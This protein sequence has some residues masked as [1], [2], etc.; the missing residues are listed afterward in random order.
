MLSEQNKISIH[1]LNCPGEEKIDPEGYIALLSNK[2]NI[3][4]FAKFFFP[5]N[6]K[7][8][9]SDTGCILLQSRIRIP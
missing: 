5:E 2:A 7:N 8:V 6:N 1:T 9:E 4:F 3:F